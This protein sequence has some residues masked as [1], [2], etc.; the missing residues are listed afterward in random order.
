MEKHNY[1][2]KKPNILF[3]FLVPSKKIQFLQSFGQISEETVSFHKIPKPGN[4]VTL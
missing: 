1:E 3:I 2:E 4:L